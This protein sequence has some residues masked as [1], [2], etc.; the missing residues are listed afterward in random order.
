MYLSLAS[1]AVGVV[2]LG[3]LAPAGRPARVAAAGSAGGRGGRPG[4][5]DAPAERGVPVAGG[6][7]AVAVERMPD[8]V[9]AR[10][11]LA[12]GLIA[13]DRPAEVIPVLERALEL[14]PTD[15]TAIQNLAAAY[16]QLG[17]V[18]GR[19]RVLRPAQGLL[20]GRV[21]ALAD[22]RGH[23][24]RPG[25]VGEGG[26]GVRPGGRA[27]PRRPRREGRGRVR[28][29]ALRAGRRPVRA[30]PGRRRPTRRF[31]RPRRSTRTGRRA[32]SDRP[33]GPS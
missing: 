30:R 15:P 5:T 33:G 31:G 9:R 21:A 27:E 20:P 22:V 24:A 28:R 11:N 17:R 14:S 26:R 19:G 4:G 6:G 23:A 13:D 32:S 25:R 16:E 8:S 2:F 29:A 7:V 12:Q 3:G 1:V 18:R 10:A